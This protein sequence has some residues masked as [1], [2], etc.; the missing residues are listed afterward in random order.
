MCRTGWIKV[1]PPP[2]GRYYLHGSIRNVGNGGPRIRMPLIDRSSNRYIWAESVEPGAGR[3]TRYEDWLSSLV[4][5]ALRSI[6]RDAEIDRVA[7]K[8]PVQLT[9]CEPSMRALPMV[10]AADP[11]AHV[12]ALELLDGAME[13][14]PRDPVPGALAAWCHGLR[15]GHHFTCN[16]QTERDQAVRPA[17]DASMLSAGDPLGFLWSIG[18]AAA[19]FELRHYDHAVRSYQRALAGQP[20]AV[21]INCFRAPAFEL[22]GKNDDAKQS[23]SA[24]GRVFPDLTI[25]HVRKGLPHTSLFLDR[26]AEGLETLGMPVS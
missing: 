21:W 18:I 9:A 5:N 25:N 4:A 3:D 15:A 20:K 2:E 22:A 17:S 14:T 26:V 23:L 16:P 13:L 1:Q 7:G 11:A 12:E 19:N 24:L 10:I 8:D 6:I